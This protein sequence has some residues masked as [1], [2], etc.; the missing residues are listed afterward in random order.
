MTRGARAAA[1]IAFL[2]ATVVALRLTAAGD[3]TAPPLRSLAELE[4]WADARGPVA[5]AIALV[6]FGAELA[7]WYL[8]GL[9]VLHAAARTLHVPAA[10][11][12][13][14]ALAGPS[15]RRVVRG[16]LGV[17][18]VVS[19]TGH[20]GGSLPTRT[21]SDT[22]HLPAH[23]SVLAVQHPLDADTATMRPVVE[24]LPGTA[25]MGPLVE[26]A[27]SPRSW[28]V[29]P[30]DSF[31]SIA[32]EVLETTWQRTPT[33]REIDPF[34]RAL[35]DINR[36]RLVAVDDP[37]LVVPGQVFDVPPVPTPTD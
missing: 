35:V 11:V 5:T 31:W 7:T 28:R 6:R 24:Q 33:D 36:D 12:L 30:G 17:G 37:D 2:V 34:W 23:A 20:A 15:L 25:R 21:A 3:L 19:S 29:E 10:V 8:L 14:D 26:P 4:A 9:S 18:F 16:A 32:A 27:D 22:M 1:W 13:A